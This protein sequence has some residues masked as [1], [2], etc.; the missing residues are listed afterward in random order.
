MQVALKSIERF[1]GKNKKGEPYTRVVIV[2]DDGKKASSFDEEHTRDWRDGDT[3]NIEL[4]QKGDFLNFNPIVGGGDMS[5]T[6]KLDILIKNFGDMLDYLKSNQVMVGTPNSKYPLP[7]PSQN[8]AM[9]ND[10]NFPEVKMN[11]GHAEMCAT[12]NVEDEN[13]VPF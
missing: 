8:M 9:N 10:S 7:T 12:V 2:T 3:V 13:N 5:V 1:D 6:E 4:Y 11:T